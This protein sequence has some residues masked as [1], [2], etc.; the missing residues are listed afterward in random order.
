MQVD[1]LILKLKAD[2]DSYHR[3][4]VGARRLTD[5]QLDAIEARGVKMGKGLKNGFNLAKTAA[6]GFIASIGVQAITSAISSGL[7]YAASLGEIAQQLGVTTDE[8]QEYRYAASQAGV[9]T[10]EM[11]LALTQLTRRIGEGLQG[12]KAQAESF[13][14]L[15]ISVR[16]AEGNVKSAGEVIPEIA[17]AMQKLGSDA[18][19]SAIG[20]DLFG[21]SFQKLLPL[22]SGGSNGV[23]ELR[24]AAQKLGIVL[25]S[26]Q[27]AKA[28]ETADKLDAVKQ[29][30]Q[31]KIAGVVADNAGSILELADALSSLAETAIKAAAALPKA[32]AA[33]KNPNNFLESIT[34]F[35]TL[36]GK[37]KRSTDY[38]AGRAITAQATKA[39]ASARG[40]VYSTGGRRGGFKADKS[41]FGGNSLESILGGTEFGA[42]LQQ[43][44]G[45]FGS[46]KGMPDIKGIGSI[47][48][49]FSKPAETVAA[50]LS[51][52]AVSI[53]QI[54]ADVAVAD[55]AI[56]GNAQ[57]VAD[58][59]KQRIEA[60]RKAE[61]LRIQQDD[62]IK[63]AKQSELIAL[64]NRLAAAK[65]AEVDQELVAENQRRLA[66]AI[67]KQADRELAAL[68][69]DARTLATLADLATTRQARLDIERSILA[70]QQKIEAKVLEEAIARGDIAD[71]ATARA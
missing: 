16:D 4:M 30:L 37:A 45:E 11:D 44:K 29:V 69:D 13:A 38:R 47:I 70:I 21:K 14:K 31:A 52:W 9:S 28:D 61:Q 5:K 26:E 53:E 65:S 20:T 22:L 68:D 24:N 40:D 71:A 55:A 18:E 32:W 39:S 34:G 58:A 23:N 35:D 12:T 63:G 25:S 50:K 57:A 17:D 51:E 2:L 59:Q 49:M 6:V 43:A 67:G 62:T 1:P 64:N 10:E 66:D 54:T 36:T 46:A 27:I 48:D 56:I 33:A 19:R 3:D 15:G 7:Q 8:L 41:N 42:I 60:D